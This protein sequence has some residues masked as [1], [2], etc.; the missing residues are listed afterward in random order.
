MN[1]NTLFDLPV[2]SWHGIAQ[3]LW[4]STLFALL[5]AALTVALRKNNARSRYWLWMAA[6]AKFLVPFSLLV[7]MGSYISWPRPYQVARLA[8]SFQME[9]SG[10]AISGF[11]SSPSQ[12]IDL[13]ATQ[14]A[15]PITNLLTTLNHLLPL[16]LLLSWAIGVLC[17]VFFWCRQWLRVRSL[18]KN[19]EPLTTGREV[20]MLRRLEP[21]EIGGTTKRL[22]IVLTREAM[23]PGIVGILR[24]VLM[25][26]QGVSCHLSDAQL[27]AILIHEISHVRRRDNLAALFHMVVEALFW[28]HPLVWWLGARLIE[29]R[30]RACDEEVLR[31]YNSPTVY[32]ESILKICQF[33]VESPLSCVSGVTGSDLKKR[34]LQ[35]MTEQVS[36]KMNF[37]RKLLLAFASVLTIA[38]PVLFGAWIAPTIHAQTA[39]KPGDISGIWQGT[40]ELPNGKGLRTVL[41][42]EKKADGTLAAKMYSI[43]QNPSPITVTTIT[44]HGTAVSYAIKPLNL[45]YE[46][47]L[48]A[49][50][51]TITGKATQ[52]GA[53]LVMN[54]AFTTPDN[55][56]AIPEPPRPMARDAHP[57][58]EVATIKPSDPNSQ[59][60]GVHP[61]GRH[62]VIQ[63]YTLNDLISFAYSVQ[64][65]QV[66]GAQDWFGSDR[67]DID[68]L[69]DIPGSPSLNQAKELVQK[70]LTD[71][72]KIVFHHEKK[73]MAVYAITIAKGGPKL[74]KSAS[75]PNS[76][77]GLFFTGYGVLNVHNAT[78]AE[79]ADL[80]QSSV[81]DK[82]VVDQTGL[83]DKYDFILKWT[84]DDSQFAT[85][86]MRKPPTTDEAS[87]PPNL[88]DAVQE[89][90]GLKMA[91]ARAEA[92]VMV[93]DHV[94]KPSAN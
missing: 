43:D 90:L 28:F 59:G 89:Q 22:E 62:L 26:P 66:V 17:V 23:E 35:I 72:F 7:V 8:S 69:P 85:M 51:K 52:G 10:F 47:V 60:K 34:I 88:Y 1:V 30:E 9:Q 80:M 65:R 53:P 83:T 40:L 11:V 61:N 33:C 75:D 58:I 71:R 50:G 91:A 44:V 84:P 92:D 49:D 78:I 20:E 38:A 19:A 2:N 32:A 21:L 63:N 15:N 41:K 5:A 68:I 42:V 64:A 27:Q 55:A 77:P 13:S 57:G 31:M 87:A 14:T 54:Y 6:S 29:E 73:E 18:V 37:S 70:L 56:W 76:P 81:L 74:T 93:I 48:S 36:L 4:Q 94:E 12:P 46:G 24:P 25:W 82:P 39:A 16:I 67:Y 45:T 3:H 86:P 79:Y